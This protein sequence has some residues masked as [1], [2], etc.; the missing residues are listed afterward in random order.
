MAWSS[1]SYTTQ[2][3][4]SDIEPNR[5]A[6]FEIPQSDIYPFNHGRFQLIVIIE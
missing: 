5:L 6:V 1:M 4:P 3:A 2:P